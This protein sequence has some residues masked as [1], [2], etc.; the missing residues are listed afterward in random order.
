MLAKL[1]W[2]FLLP[3]HLMK[4]LHI[5]CFIFSMLIKSQSCP[6]SQQIISFGKTF[7]TLLTSK[8]PSLLLPQETNCLNLSQSGSFQLL[9]VLP[10]HCSHIFKVSFFPMA[11]SLFSTNM[12][13]LPDLKQNHNK[14]LTISQIIF[15]VTAPTFSPYFHLQMFLNSS[16]N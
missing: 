4:I 5:L 16:L 8:Q 7:P 15:Q 3:D 6:Q 1:I 13:K 10:R 9:W 2:G 14:V 12:F 11:P